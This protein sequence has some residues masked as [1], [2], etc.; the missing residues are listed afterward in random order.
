VRRLAASSRLSLRLVLASG[1]PRRRDLLERL[2]IA[3][4]VRPLDIDEQPGRARHPQVL[5][6][7]LAREK[8][9]AARLV[10]ETSPILAADT[11]VWHEGSF[12]GKPANTAE[13]SAMLVD[14][15]GKVHT[16]VTA[17]A[18][19]PPGKRSALIRH[20]AT[21]VQMRDYSYDEI[22]ASIRRGDPFDKAGGYA[23]QDPILVPVES[24][25]G[26]YCNVI[27]LSLWATM[28][29]LRKA[30]LVLLDGVESRLLPECATCPLRP[31]DLV[32]QS[33]RRS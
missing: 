10:D 12:L 29:L 28:E 18:L 9:E 16:V 20:P 11:V 8:A 25:R 3:F 6:R 2:G 15:R 19:M 23:I 31:P 26:C 4:E 7:R 32:R 24:Y 30:G 13:A 27:G 14:L 22:E 1:S 5:A 21:A 33:E 17:V